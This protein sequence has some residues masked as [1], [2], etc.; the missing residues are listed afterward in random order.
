M[1]NW[2][3]AWAAAP[4]EEEYSAGRGYIPSQAVTS[5]EITRTPGNPPQRNISPALAR[6]LGTEA[7]GKADGNTIDS[8]LSAGNWSK[9][10]AYMEDR[11]GMTEDDYSR[12]E[13]RDA[14]VNA[15][16][17]FNAGNSIDVLGEMN[18]LYRGEGNEL[19]TRRGVAAEAYDLWDSLDGAF[20]GTTVGQKLDAV[21]DYARSIILDP[22][23]IVSLGFGKAGAAVATRTSTVALKELAKAAGE[24]AAKGVTG[25]VAQ[26]AARD[27][28]VNAVMRGG[29]KQLGGETGRRAATREVMG[30]IA[31]ATVS[32]TA[33]AVLSD[34]GIQQVDRMTGRAE[35]YD[36]VRGLISGG[37]GV[38]GGAAA[39]AFVVARGWGGLS[40]S[41]QSVAA[42]RLSHEAKLKE[43]AD[44]KKAAAIVGKNADQ[45]KLGFAESVSDLQEAVE[46]GR[47][48]IEE[49][50]TTAVEFS[51]D[52]NIEFMGSLY[53]MFRKGGID[54]ELMDTLDGQTRTAWII[55][56]IRDPSF[57]NELYDEIQS[58]FRNTVKKAQPDVKKK[59]LDLEEW[60]DLDAEAASQ[61]AKTMRARRMA[62]QRAIAKGNADGSIDP[63]SVKWEIDPD[64]PSKLAVKEVLGE[65][66][67]EEGWYAKHVGGAQ[68]NFIRML[69]T[70]PGTTSLNVVGWSN[71]TAMTSLTDVFR[72]ALYGGYSA[73]KSLAGDSA[74][75]AK[76]R[77]QSGHMFKMQVQK[78]RNLVDYKHTMDEAMTYLTHRPDA[79]KA[80]F[81]Y[82]AGGV[83]QGDL[84]DDLNKLAG[85]GSS[86]S[87]TTKA[88]DMIQVAYGVTAQD[89]LTKTQE[90][91]YALDKGIRREYGQSYN[92]FMKRDDLYKL[93]RP[94]KKGEKPTTEYKAFMKLEGQAVEEALG[95]V[96]ARKYGEKNAGKLRWAAEILESAR[97]VPVIGALIPFGQFFNNSIV[98]MAD[99]VGISLALK[100]FVGNN[101][102]GLELALR[103]AAGWTTIGFAAAKEKKNLEEGLAWYE[104]R[105]GDGKVVNRLY[106]FP[107]SFYKMIGRL[108]AHMARDGEVPKPLYDEFLKTFGPESVTR[109]IGDAAEELRAVGEK[110]FSGES[111][112]A[113]A[114]TII[115]TAMGMYGSGFT[116]FAEPVNAALAMSEGED[117]VEPSRNVGNKA[118]NNMIRY[119]D[120]I[121][122]NV[123]GLENMPFD[124]EGYRTENY[125]A[126]NDRDMG[127]N[128]NRQMG[129]RESAVNSSIGKLFNDVGRPQWDTALGISNPEMKEVWEK[130][131]FPLLEYNA[132]R[133]M[134]SGE[135]DSFSLRRKETT[136]KDMLTL[137]K[138]QVKSSFAATASGDKGQAALI[139]DISNLKGQGRE[140]WDSLLAVFEVSEEDLADL[141]VSQLQ[142]LKDSI[143]SAQTAVKARNKA[144]V[145][146]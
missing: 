69:V 84:I 130:Y 45:A 12:E 80:M 51:D 72:G 75:A 96:F 19:D 25:K 125:N 82:L 29:F 119:T 68:H 101:R 13:I 141:T 52:V 71:A 124:T 118:M 106:D 26:Q 73:V 74:G 7:A 27:Q 22:V 89:M 129:I 88:L 23:N 137:A 90:F 97:N 49:E 64:D 134:E 15:M 36:P 65:A 144:T 94:L 98:F 107:V 58:V 143:Q 57:P 103:A 111:E 32:D 85:E 16:R 38:F 112:W 4:E 31:G 127:A 6:A 145:G 67:K 54:I 1:A 8:L 5:P 14:F 78:F 140:A 18:Y 60:L 28:A 95:N 135:W 123:I 128:P 33:A 11:A 30:D 120:R 102:S 17:G 100:P 10:A 109:G 39:G 142:L 42:S 79:Q 61:A 59:D 126:V 37:M 50:G 53:G 83:E 114:G 92:E 86:K 132:D 3:D 48:L 55:D 44:A 34:A 76:Y 121:L 136:L 108:G 70:H 117:Y 110:I 2:Q 20:T 146:G 63:D 81:R 87:K 113:D 99:H 93:M 56:T 9:V 139:M 24:A 138:Q 122:D 115:Q 41:G 131:I 62:Y 104:E 40:N 35:V 66:P 91:M 21:G 77:Q 46:R 47:F 133:L 105:D 43:L 116:R